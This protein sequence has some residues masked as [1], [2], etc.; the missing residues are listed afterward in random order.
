MAEAELLS[1]LVQVFSRCYVEPTSAGLP[2]IVSAVCVG[3]ST[4]PISYKVKFV[5]R[6][7]Y[8]I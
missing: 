5:E 4:A 6:T 3:L 1:S 2:N 7:D 8:S